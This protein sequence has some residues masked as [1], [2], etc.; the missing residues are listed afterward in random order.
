[1]GIQSKAHE[2]SHG[3]R[4]FWVK[5]KENLA[6]ATVGGHMLPTQRLYGMYVP[7]FQD[8]KVTSNISGVDPI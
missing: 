8:C 6:E 2:L 5:V 1:M 7:H 3:T 4:Q